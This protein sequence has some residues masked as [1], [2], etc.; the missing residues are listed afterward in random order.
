MLQAAV[1][2]ARLK[3]VKNEKGLTLIEL[4]AVVVI[5]GIIA[6]IA[7]P[8]IMGAINNSRVNTD[9]ATEQA[10]T[11]AAFRFIIDREDTYSPLV[12]DQTI[13]VEA[14]VTNNYI[15]AEPVRQSGA[16]A[17]D[18]YVSVVVTRTATTENWRRTAIN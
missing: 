12:G 4:L 17:G 14:L 3:W 1:R 2:S 9:E 18:E 8:L 5:I 13:T 16:N 15:Q 7:I 6:A 11:D 10:L